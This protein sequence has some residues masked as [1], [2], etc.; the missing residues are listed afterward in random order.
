MLTRTMEANVMRNAARRRTRRIP[1]YILF[2]YYIFFKYS[3]HIKKITAVVSIAF[4][5]SH[6]LGP[7]LSSSRSDEMQT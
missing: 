2:D 1:I 4:L 6:T 5:T 7:T 3:H